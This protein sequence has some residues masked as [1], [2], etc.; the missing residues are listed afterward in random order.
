MFPSL[1]FNSIYH[2]VYNIIIIINENYNRN[3]PPLQS[4]SILPHPASYQVVLTIDIVIID[5]QSVEKRS[6]D[7]MD[8]VNAKKRWITIY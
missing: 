7:L 4:D 2:G 5:P 8:T 1:Q 6:L 3:I